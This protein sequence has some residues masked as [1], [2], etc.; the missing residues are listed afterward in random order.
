MD[1]M[2]SFAESDATDEENIPAGGIHIL[3]RIPTEVSEN[4]LCP[5]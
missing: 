3:P 4:T 1:D 2:S 5:C